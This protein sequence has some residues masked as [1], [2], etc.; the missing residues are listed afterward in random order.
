MTGRPEHDAVREARDALVLVSAAVPP[1]AALAALA[2]ALTGEYAAWLR[3]LAGPVVAAA[4]LL[5]TL[6]AALL[7]ADRIV[8]RRGVRPYPVS[9]VLLIG[10]AVLLGIALVAGLPATWPVVI[11][12]AVVCTLLAGLVVLGAALDL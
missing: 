10:V 2:G 9:R 1:T 5:A 11:G 6:A 4:L 7:L 8:A 3:W 12:F